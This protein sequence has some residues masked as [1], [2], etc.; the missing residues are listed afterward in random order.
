MV[1]IFAILTIFMVKI[2]RA[3]A[4]FFS[5]NP[6]LQWWSPPFILIFVK[7]QVTNEIFI[8][9]GDWERSTWYGYA[10]AYGV[11]AGNDLYYFSECL[12][13]RNIPIL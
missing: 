9:L 5:Q 12:L 7:K 13:A 8:M 1:Q 11:S 3:P 6:P 2:V 4:R 10:N